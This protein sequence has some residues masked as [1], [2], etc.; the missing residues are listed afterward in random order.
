[1][2][3]MLF[4][5]DLWIPARFHAWLRRLFVKWRDIVKTFARSDPKSM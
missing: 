3:V 2:P 4:D 1:M 5:V